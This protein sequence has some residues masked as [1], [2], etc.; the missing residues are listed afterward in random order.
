VT[1]KQY[2]PPRISFLVPFAADKASPHR[3]RVWNWLEE[4]WKWEMPDAEIVMGRST[5]EVFS[6][7][8]AVND[9]ASRASGRVFVILDS[10]AILDGPVIKR[11]ASAID[12]AIRWERRLWYIPYRHLYRLTEEATERV[13]TSDPRRPMRF[14]SPPPRDEVESTKGSMHGH[15]FGAMIQMMPRQAF[16]E[17]GC[18]DKRFSGWGGEDVAFVRALNTLYSKA[19]TTDNDVLHLWHEKIGDGHLDRM[20]QGQINPRSNE[21]LASRYSRATGDRAKMRALVDEGC[22]D[23]SV[24]QPVLEDLAPVPL[25]END[26]DVAE[27]TVEAVEP[28][29]VSEATFEASLD[30]EPAPEPTR[31]RGWRDRLADLIRG[32][33]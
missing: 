31:R 9:A 2:R 29:T 3:Q 24:P 28:A 19:R 7:T 14:H 20:W 21:N 32:N 25:P 13:L 17:V 26:L 12:E 1:E 16:E 23:Q 33:R 8:E 22:A 6:K 30:P 11:C 5:G 10:D 27:E 18:M 4:Y 15:R